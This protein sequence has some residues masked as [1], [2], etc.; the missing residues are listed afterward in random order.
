MPHPS[1]S[2]RPYYDESDI[3]LVTLPE[4]IRLRPAMYLGSTDS[5]ALHRLLGLTVAGILWHYRY[6]E[7]SLRQITAQLELDGSATVT[8]AGETG[9]T[10]SLSQSSHLLKQELS[11]GHVKQARSFLDQRGG[12][13]FSELCVVNACSEHLHVAIQ[14]EQNRWR[15]LQFVQGTLQRDEELLFPPNEDGDLHLR[16]WPDFTLLD[17]GA[18]DFHT[19]LELIRSLPDNHSAVP[20]TLADTRLHLA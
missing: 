16:F 10:A 19:T 9:S 14:G 1:D 6:L 12:N 8:S 5:Q 4:A 11:Q 18:F 7:Y 15:S 2:K 20:I 17:P 3:Q 13:A